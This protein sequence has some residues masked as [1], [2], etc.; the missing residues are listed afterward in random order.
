MADILCP[1]CGMP[2]PDD[3]NVCSFCRQ[4]LRV[5]SDDSSIKPG[6]MPTKKTT[7]E[8][9]PILPQW[10]RDA[11]AR[12]REAADEE[13]EVQPQAP[14]P[15]ASAASEPADWLAGLEAAAR[16]EEKEELPE[17]MRGAPAAPPPAKKETKKES[18]EETFPR[19]QEIHWE[20][21]PVD[22]PAR[23]AGETQSEDG[24]PSWMKNLQEEPA[25][26]KKDF[27][28][29]L[30][31]QEPP[32]APQ[33]PASPFEAGTF[34]PDTGELRS[35]ME[36]SHET[37][38]AAPASPAEQPAGEALPDWIANL[39]SD[40]AAPQESEP[41]VSDWLKEE[42]SKPFAPF[43]RSQAADESPLEGAF[44]ANLDLPD[45]MKAAAEPPAPP[46]EERAPSWTPPPS[47]VPASTL[48]ETPD[49]DWL[50]S[51][52][53]APSAPPAE[54]GLPDW[55]S[56]LGAPS[57]AVPSSEQTEA[58]TPDWLRSLGEP[59]AAP[60][61]SQAG[62][63][64]PEWISP[65]AE[66]PAAQPEDSFSLDWLKPPAETAATQAEEPGLP[67]WM[68]PQPGQP[69][70]A[71]PG[72]AFDWMSD[73]SK[74]PAEP[75]PPSG[76]PAFLPGEEAL[77]MGAAAAELF[78]ADM[79]DW[80]S[81]IAPTEQKPSAPEAPPGESISPADLPSWVQAMRPVETAA[82]IE[83]APAGPSEPAESAGPLA[84]LSG[85]LPAAPGYGPSARPK[86]YSLRLQ[87]TQDQLEHAALL[88]QML[89]A[90]A[91]PKPFRAAS[92][93]VLSQR[94]LR[95]AVAA[96][97]LIVI[98]GLLVTGL[99]FPPLPVQ[100]SS[101]ARFARDLVIAL[102]NDAPVLMIFDY[103]PALAGE[104]EAVA[105]SFVDQ[106]MAL[107]RPRVAVLSTSPTGVA[108]AERFM[109]GQGGRPAYRAGQDY[110]NLGY[111]PG[112]SAGIQAFASNPRETFPALKG[113]TRFSDY[114][115]VILLTDRAETA[116]AWVE[117]SA[118]HRGNG[119]FVV[120][121]SAQ[122]APMIQPY[123]LSGQVNGL[124][125]GLRDGAAF[126]QQASASAG[127]ASRYWS[128]YN[129]SILIVCGMIVIGGLWNLAL[130][131]RS[132]RLGLEEA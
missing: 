58:E 80:L 7:A 3:Q 82:P 97:L 115:L 46:K 15:S 35:W 14:E 42:S 25:E 61:V 113:V 112:E 27:S 77:G 19:R 94:V 38:P 85:V 63:G 83:A 51:E 64:L 39:G 91:E 71:E 31:K 11:R 121:S 75:A 96:V 110:D 123:L 129:F 37:P 29:W 6:D 127:R 45:W 52:S 99:Q 92:G 88:E 93:V 41:P 84:G 122:S 72:A 56:S 17:W 2:N 32:A 100:P 86:A 54:S 4:P 124:V 116:R 12:A 36:P 16:E 117:Q 13:S 126:D 68:K 33:P 34:R 132:R 24:I 50:K 104:M 81:N 73:S 131:L 66:T 10:L 60:P 106:M 128:A 114:A 49:F 8:L 107:K 28:D 47:S 21:E 102:P 70:P 1:N 95:W 78:S 103:E 57:A 43:Q 90:E 67:D 20:S 53:P 105:A 118:G 109:S 120:V 48:E 30:S 9:E 108:L 98:V 79:P 111:L 101:E 44:D 40:R 23:P 87:P 55:M 62:A 22:E 69:A 18:R 76:A 59:S 74:T 125:T 5:A 130:N 26:E 89:A 65:A 119:S